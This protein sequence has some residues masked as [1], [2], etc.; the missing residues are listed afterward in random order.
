MSCFVWDKSGEWLGSWGQLI[1]R[2]GTS[3][4][5]LWG[6]LILH[7]VTKPWELMGLSVSVAVDNFCQL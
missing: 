5:I 6:V 3:T 1:P 7:L 4:I 2:N